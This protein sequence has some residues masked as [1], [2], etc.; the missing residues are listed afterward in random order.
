[1]A[2]LIIIFE[3]HEF[4]CDSRTQS[5]DINDIY[6]KMECNLLRPSLAVFSNLGHLTGAARGRTRDGKSRMILRFLFGACAK[7]S[8]DLGMFLGYC[9]VY[10]RRMILRVF[11]QVEL[12]VLNAING[13][14][15]KKSESRKC[16][17]IL[18]WMAGLMVL[19]LSD[20]F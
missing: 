14:K 17:F 15:N 18:F 20:M 3:W 13:K 4:T 16:C 11:L 7:F 8:G 9:C 10:C 2:K 19:V 6:G 1:M 5:G 12:G